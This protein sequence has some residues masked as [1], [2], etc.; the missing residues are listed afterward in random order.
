MSAQSRWE[1][2]WLCTLVLIAIVGTVYWGNSPRKDSFLAATVQPKAESSLPPQDDTKQA[3]AAVQ[4]TVRDTADQ[5]SDLQRQLKLLSEQI[6][7]LAA[8]VDSLER[9]THRQRGP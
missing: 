7:A 9:A 6:G 2:L 4:Q 8:R 3:V 1:P 5:V